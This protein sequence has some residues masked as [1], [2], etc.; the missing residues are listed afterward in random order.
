MDDVI[1]SLN[2]SGKLI[3]VKN[4]SYNSVGHQSRIIGQYF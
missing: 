2:I 3:Y 1:L 4:N